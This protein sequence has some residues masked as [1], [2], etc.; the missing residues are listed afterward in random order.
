MKKLIVFV[1]VILLVAPCVFAAVK[2]AA[3]VPAKAADSQKALAEK[4]RAEGK[5]T[6]YANITSVEPILEDFGKK[7]G[8]KAEYTRL[9]TTKFIA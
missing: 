1:A 4:A 6:F 5:V 3:K 9:S 8:V 7:Y 2:E